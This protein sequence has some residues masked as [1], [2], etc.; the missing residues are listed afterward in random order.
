MPSTGHS[1]FVANE[2]P[3]QLH[4]KIEDDDNRH[5]SPVLPS[6]SVNMALPHMASSSV[7]GG[8][9][10]TFNT[11]GYYNNRSDSFD[12][13]LP[14]EHHDDVS[15]STSVMSSTTLMFKV[16]FKST[17]DD[18]YLSD[19]CTRD[20]AIGDCVKVEAD[21]GHDVGTVCD[22]FWPSPEEVQAVSATNNKKII[23]LATSDELLLSKGKS[24]D[25]ARALAICKD[26]IATRNMPV[27]L[28][29]A[30]YQYDRKKLTFFFTS[31]GHTDFRELV[32]DL[33]TIFK[34]RIWMQKIK[35]FE[36]A[37]F[38]N[39]N[40]PIPRFNGGGSPSLKSKDTPPGSP[41]HSRNSSRSGSPCLGRGQSP[42]RASGPPRGG[43]PPSL[44]NGGP[45][46]CQGYGAHEDGRQYL[47]Q[48]LGN[49][50]Y[51]SPQGGNGN[52]SGYMPQ[53][54]GP[55]RHVAPGGGGVG[56]DMYRNRVHHHAKH[57]STSHDLLKQA[58]HQAAQFRY[59]PRP[60]NPGD[61]QAGYAYGTDKSRGHGQHQYQHQHQHQQ[62]S[63]QPRQVGGSSK[64]YYHQ[65]DPQHQPQPQAHTQYHS[66]PYFQSPAHQQSSPGH[67]E[68]YQQQHQQQPHQQQLH[69]QAET[70]SLHQPQAQGQCQGQ[71]Q[72]Q[73]TSFSSYA[74]R[75]A[76][77]TDYDMA[78]AHSLPP[79]P[80]ERNS[81]DSHS[82][83]S[84]PPMH[85]SDSPVG[86]MDSIN[87]QTN[88][89][90]SDTDSLQSS[91]MGGNY[92][93]PP[94]ESRVD[95]S[96]PTSKDEFCTSPH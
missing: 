77:A 28:V 84:D 5:S 80:A 43:P 13:F 59:L 66:S 65:M 67:Q 15:S 70:G 33:F 96:S 34:T 24:R 30:E 75:Y 11:N 71:G 85:F 22:V 27:T 14:P 1:L 88:C 48:G 49:G 17:T 54:S 69:Q 81:L 38:R 10:S 47:N 92:P 39:S 4:H 73:Y 35:P 72:P 64:P 21:R 50:H 16:Q 8:G 93:L 44:F 2:Q 94:A 26:V 18:F 55:G 52:G 7:P 40:S 78:S 19:S 29:D 68:S 25:E 6:T 31:D 90:D 57:S 83:Y 23:S 9:N 12:E 20:I 51:V 3:P 86:F 89:S 74:E 63:H 91:G 56:N 37:A 58:T 95:N 76:K 42:L 45:Q 62:Y 53:A 79:P 32:R 60:V 87:G 41:S 36:A 61:H 82:G 46:P